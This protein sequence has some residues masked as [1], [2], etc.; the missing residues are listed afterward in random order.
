MA[1]KDFFNAIDQSVLNLYPKEAIP[2]LSMGSGTDSGV[3]AASLWS[4]DLDFKLIC[5]Q[6][7]EDISIL[8]KRIQLVDKDALSMARP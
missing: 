1:H 4:Q 3:I 5:F 2:V 6:A 7:N 8:N